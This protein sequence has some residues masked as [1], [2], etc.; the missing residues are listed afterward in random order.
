MIKDYKQVVENDKKQFLAN[1]KKYGWPEWNWKEAIF[2]PAQCILLGAVACL[3]IKLSDH[4]IITP[5]NADPN[6]VNPRQAKSWYVDDIDEDPGMETIWKYNGQ[7]YHMKY[8][9]ETNLVSVVPFEKM[10]IADDGF[11]DD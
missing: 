11:E 8:D 4:Y 2:A 5:V 10:N 9:A 7:K 6:E 1:V 3:A